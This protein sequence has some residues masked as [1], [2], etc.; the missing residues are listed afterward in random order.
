MRSNAHHIDR[1]RQLLRQREYNVRWL[2]S[3]TAVHSFLKGLGQGIALIQSE[4]AEIQNPVLF[5]QQL[6]TDASRMQLPIT[7]EFTY[8][9]STKNDHLELVA[10]KASVFDLSVNY[11]MEAKPSVEVPSAPHVIKAVREAL[12]LQAR[13]YFKQTNGLHDAR[14]RKKRSR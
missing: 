7:Y 9:Y 14:V 4:Y 3:E 11:N 13:E 2:G 6:F 10:I 5:S 1:Q 8:T 12:T